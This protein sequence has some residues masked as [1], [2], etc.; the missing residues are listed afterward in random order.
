MSCIR[1]WKT[2]HLEDE[3]RQAVCSVV[4]NEV[5][6]AE[7]YNNIG[8]IL[9]A[10]TKLP[11][12]LD[13]EV[14][15]RRHGYDSFQQF[16]T[17]GVLEE[18][19]NTDEDAGGLLQIDYRD[20]RPIFFR[21]MGSELNEGHH[22]RRGHWAGRSLS[23][24]A[25]P[26]SRLDM[27]PLTA[28]FGVQRSP[29]AR[30]HA[31]RREAYHHRGH[32]RSQSI[33]VAYRLLVDVESNPR[34][35]DD[36]Y[37]E[38]GFEGSGTLDWSSVP[39]W[40]EPEFEEYVLQQHSELPPRE[41]LAEPGGGHLHQQPIHEFQWEDYNEDDWE[42]DSIAPEVNAHVDPSPPAGGS[43]E[44]HVAIDPERYP[45]LPPHV[46][47]GTPPVH[48]LAEV[49]K[50]VRAEYPHVSDILQDGQT[51]YDT[52][53]LKNFIDFH[54]PMLRAFDLANNYHV[55]WCNT[56][57]RDHPRWADKFNNA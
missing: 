46:D 15:A 29:A 12:C 42:P 7:G 16:V 11:Y 14:E 6:L 40:D 37:N 56:Y 41:D 52:N 57:V 45:N 33:D 47:M 25:A 9:H 38:M 23:V 55:V 8:A 28:N 4:L 53:Q 30:A 39:D 20:G 10:I 54:L 32:S 27:R 44:W 48:E 19:A 24:G 17:S 34:S 35:E 13:G 22:E 51:D 43:D 5:A 49:E 50:Q 18:R 2:T 21:A 36:I 31:S 3:L 1:K 26:R